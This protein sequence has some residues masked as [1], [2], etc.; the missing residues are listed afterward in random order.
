MASREVWADVRLRAAWARQDWAAILREYRRAAGLSQRGL[1]PIVGMPQPHIS[2]IESGRRQVTSAELM[3]RI[4]EGLHVPEELTGVPRPQGPDAWAPQAELRERIA[5]AHSAGR[6]DLRTADWIARVLAQHR[7]AEDEVLGTALWGIVRQQLDAVTGLIPH[8]AGAAADRLMLLAAEHAHW[9]SWVA[10]QSEQRGPALAWIDLAHGWAV[11][12]GHADMA[13]WAQR[14]RAYYSLSHGD[15]VRA[16]RTAEAARYVGPRTL[17]P[18]AEAAAVHQEAMAAAQVGERDRASRL[19]EEACKLALRVPAE[20]ERPGW[21]YWLD[22]TRARLQ[23][24]D[25]AYACQRWRDAA[26][27]F[28][29]AL[30]SLVAFPR[31]HAY[32]QARLDDAARRS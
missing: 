30:P 11:D 6:A 19:A 28:R 25:A 17:S 3:A 23:V 13:S 29:T 16:L 22:P 32:Y 1:E 20:E 31:D 8:A 26:D 15:P 18:A 14:I 21:L 12:G 2:A 9:L 4:T 5:H 27:G 7:R 24:A 10:W